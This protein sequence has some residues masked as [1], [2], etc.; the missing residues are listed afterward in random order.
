MDDLRA[1][2]DA[3]GCERAALFGVSEGGPM[4]ALFAATYPDRVSRWSSTEP[5]RACTRRPTTPWACRE[6]AAR[7]LGGRMGEQW[8]EGPSRSSSW[9]PS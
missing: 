1:V 4:S 7:R 9:A 8:G 5:S 3:A 6:D 2:M